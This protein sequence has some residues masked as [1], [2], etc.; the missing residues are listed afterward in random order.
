MSKKQRKQTETNTCLLTKA[1]TF[2]PF[3]IYICRN[4][5]SPALNVPQQ[6]TTATTSLT[7]SFSSASS[8]NN[9]LTPL[10]TIVNSASA[11]SSAVS[12]D[13]NKSQIQS[14]TPL[15]TAATS[16]ESTMSSTTL[17]S[18]SSSSSLIALLP[19]S[20]TTSSSSSAS[21]GNPAV[22]LISP[23]SSVNYDQVMLKQSTP[24]KL[25]IDLQSNKG[26]SKSKK[27]GQI[28]KLASVR[29]AKVSPLLK[30]AFLSP[31]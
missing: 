30:T 21:L 4:E 5:S 28:L 25:Q 3:F 7:P 29:G 11:A 8:A 14:I 10:T 17:A 9:Y 26:M 16:A 24:L 15:L 23:C 18:S 13:L 22:A 6:D 2:Y 27:L 31:P 19:P 12:C 20:T 1:Q